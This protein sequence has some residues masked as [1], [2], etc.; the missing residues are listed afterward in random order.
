MCFTFFKGLLRTLELLMARRLVLLEVALF[1]DPLRGLGLYIA[2][3][4]LPLKTIGFSF[5]IPTPFS[6]LEG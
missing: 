4:L 1:K 2:R 3:R 5:S 6:L